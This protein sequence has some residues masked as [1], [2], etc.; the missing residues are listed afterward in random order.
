MVQII[1][2]GA[3]LSFEISLLGISLN[4]IFIHLDYRNSRLMVI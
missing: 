4:L 3:G 1:T 2:I